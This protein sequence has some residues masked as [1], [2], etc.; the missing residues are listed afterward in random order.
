MRRIGPHHPV[1]AQ[2]HP[3]PHA[4]PDRPAAVRFGPFELDLRSGELSRD[5]VRTR[6]QDQPLA[7]LAR[8]VERPGELV[9]RDELRRR[10]WPNGTIVDF[11]HGV[12]TALRRLRDALGDDA[13]H[14]VYIETVP[15]RGYRFIAPVTV[16]GTMASGEARREDPRVPPV[17]VPVGHYRVVEPI[18][19]GAMGEVF[20]G[21]DLVLKRSVALK[22]LP[23]AWVDD[24]DRLA[25]FQREA[26]VLASLNHPHIA[27]I[28][29]LAEVEGRRCLVLSSWKA[30]HWPTGLCASRCRSRRPLRMPRRSPRR[31]TPRT[32][33]ASCTAI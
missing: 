9:T 22:F 24:P 10:L 33:T 20:R 23:A 13:D 2:E 14:P 8:L 4:A 17:A 28:Y 19:S 26:E 1:L 29:G 7:L 21:E 27:A 15:R 31:W 16:I 32:S 18:G 11:E 3:M 12:N 5:G 25:R 6:L 30:R